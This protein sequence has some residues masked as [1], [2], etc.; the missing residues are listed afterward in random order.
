MNQ[1]PI[2]VTWIEQAHV[3]PPNEIFEHPT[4]EDWDVYNKMVQ[5]S[6]TRKYGN[7]IDFT[8]SIFG[9]TKAIIDS[10][11]NKIVKIN[12]N[13]LTVVHKKKKK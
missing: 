4:K 7:I 5:E 2:R 8:T 9:I 6:K 12:I 3:T 11:D 13:K 1:E 10:G